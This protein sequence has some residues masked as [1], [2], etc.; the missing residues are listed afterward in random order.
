M[1]PEDDWWGSGLRSKLK[2]DRRSD[3]DVLSVVSKS[4]PVEANEHI[5]MR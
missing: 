1:E 5:M 2:R 4:I 3:G